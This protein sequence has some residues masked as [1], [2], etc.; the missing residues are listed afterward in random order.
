LP[1]VVWTLFWV[2][3]TLVQGILGDAWCALNP[4]YGPWRLVHLVARGRIGRFTLPARLGRWPA[5]A[6]L[7]AFG[8][9]ELVDIA[10]DNPQRLACVITAYWLVTFAGM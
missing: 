3:L 8:W 10:P 2:G 7:L 6:G 9:F 5:V 1:L 4:W